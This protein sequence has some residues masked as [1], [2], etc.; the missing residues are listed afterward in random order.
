MTVR[1][2]GGHTESHCLMRSSFHFLWV[3]SLWLGFSG[4]Y[5]GALGGVGYFMVFL[6]QKSVFVVVC[7]SYMVTGKT[8]HFRLSLNRH[9]ERSCNAAESKELS[10]GK[11]S[12]DFTP[13]CQARAPFRSG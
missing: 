8:S 10:P 5:A 1:L 2:G 6:L 4:W 12:F 9:P 11:R 3:N 7:R 13:R